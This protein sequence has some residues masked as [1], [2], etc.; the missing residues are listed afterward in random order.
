MD[1]SAVHIDDSLLAVEA[2]RDQYMVVPDAD[3][4]DLWLV[5]RHHSEGGVS[6]SPLEGS[7]GAG[8][9][10]FESFVWAGRLS[11]G[12]VAVEVETDSG[13]YGAEV[14]RGAWIVSVPWG[15]RTMSYDIRQR[16]GSGIV[17][18]SERGILHA[19]EFGVDGP[20]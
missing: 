14:A 3:T 11:A 9:A 5:C 18:A 1:F 2:D 4:G 17:V 7:I 12:V 20:E 19:A 15:N 16:D 8:G 6:G 10:P 13:V